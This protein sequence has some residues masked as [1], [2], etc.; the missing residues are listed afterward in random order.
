MELQKV[1]RVLAFSQASFLKNYID[2]CTLLRQESKTAFS[3]NLWKLFANSVFGKF[4]EQTR[5]YVDCKI[6]VDEIPC[7]KW[8]GSPRFSNMKIISENLVIIF[9]KRASITL[10]KAF[11]IGFTILEKSKHFMY[12][13]YYDVIKPAVEKCEV[14]MSD[15]DS[16]V[17]AIESSEKRSNLEKIKEIID[18]SNYPPDHKYYDEK[19]KNKLGFWKDEL[20]GKK[21][22]E[23]CGLR[24]KTYAFRIKKS[25]NHHELQSKCKGITKAYKKKIRFEDYKKCV[26]SFAKVSITQYQ[27]R[28]KS[29]K[30]FT[31]KIQKAAFSSFD[32][33]RYL[34]SCGLHSVG[35][36]SCLINNDSQTCFFCESYNPLL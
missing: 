21:M 25:K 23:F 15:T 3:K 10:N 14:I 18:F 32:D 34:M 12:Q 27:I 22:T 7:R 17:L 20:Q 8:T 35:Y 24:S 26:Q 11:P 13:Q 4:I 2:Q 1:H 28:S 29:H 6:V 30:I 33:K 16:L 5:N 36:G 9:M 31:A 19:N